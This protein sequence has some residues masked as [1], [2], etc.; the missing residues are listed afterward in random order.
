MTNLEYTHRWTPLA[1]DAIEDVYFNENTGT[2]YIDFKQSYIYAKDDTDLELFRE[3]GTADSAGTFYNEAR[4]AGKLSGLRYVDHRHY[5]NFEQVAPDLLAPAGTSKD[6]K[7]TEDTLDT[8]G[9][10]SLT[11]YALGQTA[12]PATAVTFNTNSS[13]ST[14][15]YPGNGKRDHETWEGKWTVGFVLTDDNVKT[16]ESTEANSPESAIQ[17]LSEL[18]ARLGIFNYKVKWVKFDFNE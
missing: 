18:S 6:L 3:L 12:T 5:T 8:S 13:T 1:S 9:T 17:E 4:R 16:F 7:V 2:G 10:V 15:V 14:F 11:T